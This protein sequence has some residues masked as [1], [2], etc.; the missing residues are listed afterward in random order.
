M[1]FLSPQMGHGE[2]FIDFG[3]SNIGFPGNGLWDGEL[4][5]KGFLGGKLL[6]VGTMS[7]HKGVGDA[8]LG[9]GKS[10][11]FTWLLSFHWSLGWGGPAE[12]PQRELPRPMVLDHYWLQATPLV[13]ATPRGDGA[14]SSAPELR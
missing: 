4:P 14:G 11:F 1:S 8:C 7:T 9:R 5:V 6:G 3:E 2:S 13:E 10:W 12:E